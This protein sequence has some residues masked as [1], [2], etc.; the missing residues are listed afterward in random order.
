M[1]YRS[2]VSMLLFSFAL[3][4]LIVTPAASAST[5]SPTPTTS[6]TPK[7]T[8]T[9][10]RVLIQVIAATAEFRSGPGIEYPIVYRAKRG[11]KIQLSGINASGDWYEF[12]YASSQ[13][14]ITADEKVVKLIEGNIDQLSEV[15]APPVPT[16][17]KT[18]PPKPASVLLYANGVA[19]VRVTL[20]EYRFV[21][22][23]QF[24][25]P[26]TGFT[27]LVA[28]LR[29]EN[30]AYPNTWQTSG[31]EFKVL[32][33]DGALHETSYVS[34]GYDCRLDIV[35]IVPGGKAEGCTSFEVPETGSLS[36]V[37]APFEYSQYGKD[38]AAVFTVR[39]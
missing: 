33:G 34:E 15:E 2:T 29:I 1:K 11:N 27:F 9:S 31:Y 38:R 14:W 28:K 16:P 5:A 30:L 18:P 17:T 35:E 37:Y 7:V 25:K 36:I 23:E 26:R 8:S 39:K 19:V 3:I 24:N 13:A 6:P 4:L 22:G 10:S 20:L 21:D 12:T 32:D